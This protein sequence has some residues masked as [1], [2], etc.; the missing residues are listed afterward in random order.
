MIIL[1]C[2][3]P[4]ISNLVATPSAPRKVMVYLI[5][6]D[7]PAQRPD[8]NPS[9]HLGMLTLSQA[10]LPT[11]L[12]LLRCLK[13]SSSVNPCSSRKPTQKSRIGY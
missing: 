6:I 2:S 13:E 12:T 5:Q 7:W 11:C 10:P 1:L 9:E 8:L 3:H 4:K